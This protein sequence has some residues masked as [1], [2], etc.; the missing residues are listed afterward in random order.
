MFI[1]PFIHK[2]CTH[3]DIN[4]NVIKILTIGGKNLWE[5]NDSLNI[6]TDILTPNEIF[7][8][9]NIIKFDEKV[10][11]CEVDLKKTNVNDFYKWEEINVNDRDTFCWRTFIILLGN[12]GSN[13]LDTSAY[14]VLDGYSVKDL[15]SAISSRK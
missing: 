7:I 15:S 8:T 5:E 11:L 14:D 3:N 12:N 10:Q 4:V 2:V 13:W 6:H 1:I 9:G